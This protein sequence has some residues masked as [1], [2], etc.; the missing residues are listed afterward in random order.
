MGKDVNIAFIPV[1]PGYYADGKHGIRIENLVV[2]RRAD[3]PSN[4]QETGFMEMEH[5]TMC[6]IQTRLVEPS[7]LSPAERNW[8][9]GYNAEVKAKL[10]KILEGYGDERA[11][12]WLE[13]E[14]EPLNIEN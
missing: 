7:M 10:W 3:T 2:V 13:R 5:L 6:P 1:E 4:F 8:L 12:R 14:C 11:L 9:D